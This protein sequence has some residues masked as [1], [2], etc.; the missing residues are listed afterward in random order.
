MLS[1]ET[2]KPA[3]R[4]SFFFFLVTGAMV[5]EGGE[6]WQQRQQTGSPAVGQRRF[7]KGA[8]VRQTS[9]QTNGREQDQGSTRRSSTQPVCNP[10]VGCAYDDVA[11]GACCPLLGQPKS[12]CREPQFP[13]AGYLAFCSINLSNTYLLL[14]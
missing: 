6:Q 7:L 2:R 12:R 13:V 1:F 5:V 4:S 8:K 14:N 10:P 9:R 11:C 3:P